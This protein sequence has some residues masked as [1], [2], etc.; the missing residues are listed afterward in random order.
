MGDYILSFPEEVQ[1]H[2]KKIRE[3]IKNAAPHSVEN[4]SYQMP[5]YKLY[6]KPLVYFAAYKNHIG[7][8]GTPSGHS[9][10]AE[11]LAAYKQG[12][13]S[14]QFPLTRPIPFDLIQQMVEFRVEENTNRSR[15]K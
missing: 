5:A 1:L 4:I 7:F 8:Y 13:G 11:K 12:K 15:K 9:A 10:F 6:N 2:L 14:V 3:I